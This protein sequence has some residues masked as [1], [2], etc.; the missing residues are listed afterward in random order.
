MSQLL[1]QK[2]KKLLQPKM[3]FDWFAN[4]GENNLKVA[5][6]VAFIYHFRN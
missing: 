1:K 4:L 2:K 3:D 6:A 5:F